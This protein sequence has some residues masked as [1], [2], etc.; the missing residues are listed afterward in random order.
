MAGHASQAP[1]APA[2]SRASPA[3]N[4]SASSEYINGHASLPD[5]PAPS[6]A[7]TASTGKKGKSKK[8]TDPN[9]T[10]KLLA[11]KINQLELDAAGEKD[12]DA[13]IGGYTFTQES[14]KTVLASMKEHDLPQD[15]IAE[16]AKALDAGPEATRSGQGLPSL[17]TI[18]TLVAKFSLHIPNLNLARAHENLFARPLPVNSMDRQKLTEMPPGLI[19]DIEREV[20]KATRDLSNLLTGMETPLS[21]LEEVQKRYTGL[22]ADM[23]RMERDNTKNKKR[24][25]LLQKEKD[26]GRSDLSKTNSMKEKLEKLCRELQRENKKLKVSAE[27]THARFDINPLKFLKDE[28]KKIE[29]SERRSRDEFS[30]R[31]NSMYS[32]IDETMDQ[33]ENPE[34]QKINVEQDE[35]YA[36]QPTF[37]LTQLHLV[38]L[39]T[40]L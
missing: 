10:S 39:D 1:T 23:K 37:A 28:Q 36:L 19:A 5:A 21:R 40:N 26:Q 30:D 14:K 12:Q 35:M 22:L 13:E 8:T 18:E 6:A 16:V 25:D 11:A 31:T 29:D 17:K 33:A 27:F 7:P 3:A 32:A 15:M 4:N 20:K 34:R 24:A 2:S 9:E 38:T